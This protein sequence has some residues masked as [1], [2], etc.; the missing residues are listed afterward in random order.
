MGKFHQRAVGERAVGVEL[1]SLERG[2]KDVEG[3]DLKRQRKNFVFLFF[4]LKKGAKELVAS[5]SLLLARSRFNFSIANKKTNRI[6]THPH[7][8]R[9]LAACLGEGLGNG[10]SEAL[11]VGNTGYKGLLA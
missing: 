10:P 1:A 3:R 5:R 4:F 9:D 2:L 6:Q 11:V 8:E 7:A